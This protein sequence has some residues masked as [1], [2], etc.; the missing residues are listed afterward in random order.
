MK[1][2]LTFLLTL[3]VSSLS[4]VALAQAPANNDCAGAIDLG[5]AGTAA[6]CPPITFTN[7]NA[8]SSP[9]GTPSNVGPTCFNGGIHARDVWFKFTVPLTGGVNFRVA[10]TATLNAGIRNP[11]IALLRGFCAGAASVYSEEFCA[12][13]ANAATTT[14]IDATSL[15]PGETYYVLVNDWSTTATPNAGQFNIC[16]T[17][18]VPTYRMVVNSG[19]TA[20]S[21]T[22]YD[23]GGPAG[24]YGNNESSVFRIC[25]TDPHQCITL[26]IDSLNVSTVGDFLEIY[27]VNAANNDSIQLERANGINNTGFSVSARRGACA[28][29]RFVSDAT[30][31]AAGF[32][33]RWQCSALAC[34][35]PAP[36]TCAAPDVIP[37]LPFT[38]TGFTTCNDANSVN[39]SQCANATFLANSR[40]H[41][42]AYTSLFG[43]ECISLS[44]TGDQPGTGIA[45]FRDCPTPTSGLCLGSAGGGTAVNPTIQ[46]ASF[47][48][49]GTYYIVVSR[50]NTCTPFNLRIDT[51]SC[52]DIL[53]A[54]GFCDASLSVNG[55][56]RT[57]ARPD[58]IQVVPGGGDQTFISDANRGCIV[59]PQFNYAFFYF[60]AGA[61]GQFGFIAQA[62]NPTLA[63]DIDFSVFG[64]IDSLNQICTFSRNNQPVRSSWTGGNLPTGM[65][66][67]NFQVVPPIRVLDTFD[68][69]T[70]P[71][72][73]GIAN[74]RFVRRLQVQRGKYYLVFLDDFGR[75][76]TQGG[77]SMDFRGT[78]PGIL[79]PVD[80]FT[81]RGDT[82]LCPG[83]SAFIQAAGGVLYNWTPRTGLSAF[84]VAR[85]L[86][87]PTEST[88]YN[89]RISSTCGV[90]TGNVSV[91]VFKVTPQADQTVCIGED[92]VFRMGNNFPRVAGSRWEWVLPSNIGQDTFSSTS[93]PSPRYVA[94][95]PG[96]KTF[97]VRLITPNCVLA[98]TFNITV[99]AGTAPRFSVATAYRASR[100]TGICVGNS[101]NLMSGFDPTATY[102]WSS[103]PATAIGAGANPRVTPA[104]GTTIRYL[105]TAT[106]TTCPV[107]SIDSVIIR[108]AAA[109]SIARGVIG[110]DTSLCRGL[111]VVLGRTLAQV[112]TTYSWS[113]GRFL[114]DSTI[115]NPTSIAL[116]T[117]RYI[118]TVSN[119]A[120]SIKDTITINAINLAVD[121]PDTIRNCR[122]N[123]LT[124]NP[125]RTPLGATLIW[126]STDN[127]FRDSLAV[128]IG[129]NPVRQTRYVAR[130]EVPGCKRAD[131]VLVLV[132][133]LPWFSTAILPRDTSI[134][135]GNLVV[136]RS[137]R[138][139]DAVLFPR[140]TNKW[141]SNATGPGYQSPDSLFN[142]VVIPSQTM[143]FTRTMVNGGC[144]RIDTAR[145]V[146]IPPPTATITPTNPVICAGQS[147][148]LTA[149]SINGSTGFEWTGPN[150]TPPNKAASIVVTPTGTTSYNV[151]FSD[152]AKVCGSNLSVTVVVNPL[153]TATFP[154]KTSYCLGD[155]IPQL[156]TTPQ[157]N[158]T[159]AWTATPATGIFPNATAAAP[160]AKPV[161]G[162]YRFA[163]NM[164]TNA[165]CTRADSFSVTVVGGTLNVS[166]D[167]SICSNTNATLI[168]TG[169]ATSGTGTYR[170]SNNATTPTIT[171]TDTATAQRVNTY[172]VTYSFG[173]GCSLSKPVKV[174]IIPNFRLSVTSN[175]VPNRAFDQGDV[176]TLNAITTGP[177][178]NPT[179]TW[180]QNTV[181]AGNTATISPKVLEGDAQDR[182]VFTVRVASATGCTNEASISYLVRFPSYAIPNAFTPNG[183]TLNGDFSA[184]FGGGAYLSQFNPLNDSLS[185]RP[186][187]HK[188]NIKLQSVQIYDRFGQAVYN[189]INVTT[190]NAA[191]Y[192]GWNGKRD[193]TGDAVPSD[194]YVYIIKLVMPDGSI[195]NE[196]GEVNVIR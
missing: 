15:V 151:S 128:T 12:S 113:P 90:T 152:S 140:I 112:G 70:T 123:I 153:P 68:C 133:S 87:S 75:Q 174:T 51:V 54:N 179:Y 162:T 176:V 154:A 29:V 137:A 165:G 66:D 77:I 193:N 195:R 20:C 37:S 150:I 34:T 132:D 98:D 24:V 114:N 161:A 192:K 171:V 1:H 45:V 78:D 4:M 41:V 89:V 13:S 142:I 163:V 124:L 159:Y 143:R 31:T 184:V 103:T 135:V 50:P 167:T 73:P 80:S 39:G 86:V 61:D 46:Y 134:C 126:R 10:V 157:N 115:A 149:N 6:S 125:T 181:G 111:P 3:M 169:T 100:D 60:R 164:T 178:T 91:D 67:S 79:S 116:D 158:W 194:V 177:V 55:C 109:P 117:T 145:I 74:D 188:G 19:S 196:T 69:Q 82:A 99:L 25:P 186:R 183:D 16:V 108:T 92:L 189:E 26:T 96:V 27:D 185:T 47:V 94:V 101:V 146:V 127:V 155:S 21:G 144:T 62:A 85:P 106:S 14:A 56:N 93:S 36:T 28:S 35:T 175:K 30:T 53:P 76:I 18:F 33:L 48:N 173:Q 156:N 180:T 160:G 190:L 40:D 43:G 120:C 22:L 141:T 44:V 136:L 2:F 65:A 49:P 57:N 119:G 81:T 11:E 71:I 182:A 191:T 88:V 32:K 107:A 8:T 17:E 166:A 129:V 131:S 168:A 172:T 59:G 95:T 187:L 105:L 5:T 110:R 102:S 64:P 97:I 72:G 130:L 139:Y 147:V 138:A 121:L 104:G 84:N 63:S 148:R 38:G 7:L 23:S 170:W 58:I 9:L 52:R 83:Q 42:F 122:G 118:L